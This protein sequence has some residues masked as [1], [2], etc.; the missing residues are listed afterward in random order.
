MLRLDFYSKMLCYSWRI[1]GERWKE[2][3]L[4]TSYSLPAN[5]LDMSWLDQAWQEMRDQVGIE[6]RSLIGN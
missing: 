1:F 5:P 6:K 3:A 4:L 2:E